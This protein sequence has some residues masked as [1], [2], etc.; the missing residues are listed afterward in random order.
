LNKLT[1]QLG[2]PKIM[3][4]HLLFAGLCFA[5]LS[6]SGAAHA[7]DPTGIW[8]IQDRDA[9]IRVAACGQALCANVVWIA[10]PNDPETGK[11]WT[12][13][14]NTD[15]GKRNRPLNGVA[16]TNDMKLGATPDKWS[17]HVYSVKH[18][19]NYGG[20][21]TLLSPTRM[22]IEGCLMLICESEIWTKQLDGGHAG[23]SLKAAALPR[24]GSS[25]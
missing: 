24:A 16:I 25:E 11:P 13:K 4:R 19:G 1:Q 10:K 3:L 23:R 12:D 22:K 6:A 7:G 15:A 18:G 14:H 21:L 9:E 17:G 2:A 8:L 5:G 20:S